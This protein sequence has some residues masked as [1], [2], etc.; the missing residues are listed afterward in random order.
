MK[1]ICKIVLYAVL[2]LAMLTAGTSCSHS[3][4]DGDDSGTPDPAGV[5]LLA[6]WSARRS[7]T[8][9]GST[10]FEDYYLYLYSNNYLTYRIVSQVNSD[11]ATQALYGGSWELYAGSQNHSYHF[12]W[13]L[14]DTET[15]Y[16]WGD[17]DITGTV[18][19]VYLTENRTIMDAYGTIYSS[20]FPGENISFER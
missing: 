8:Y 1:S 15:V 5:V 10:Y 9:N 6:E 16:T 14:T 18:M 11:T 17:L 2:F 20:Q 19:N 4:S 3:S 12:Q 7:Y 13:N